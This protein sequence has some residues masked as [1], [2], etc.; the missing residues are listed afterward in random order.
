MLIA[1]FMLKLPATFTQEGGQV[2]ASFPLLDVT[3]QGSTH[4]EAERNLIEATQ[5]FI[6]SCFERNVLDA[7]L[8]DCGFKA[9]HEANMP[10]KDAL[11]V[12]VNLLAARNGSPS[13]PC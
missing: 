5:L 3:S 13:H 10:D 12:P 1:Q 4:E 6:E 8:K 2:V 11:T 9:S 7:V